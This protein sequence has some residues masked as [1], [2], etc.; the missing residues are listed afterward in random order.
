MD[1]AIISRASG[2]WLFSVTVRFTTESKPV[3]IGGLIF[4]DCDVETLLCGS[5]EG[6]SL[7]KLRR[8]DE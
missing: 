7:V 6:S 8:R 5:Q 3:D 1:Q 4:G 2:G